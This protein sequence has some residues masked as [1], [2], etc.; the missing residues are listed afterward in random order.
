[1]ASD[2]FGGQTYCHPLADEDGY[3]ELYCK[4]TRQCSVHG[5]KPETCKAGPVTFDVNFRTRKVEFYL[6][7][8]EV[9]A[10]GGIL[11]ANKKALQ[12]HLEAAMEEINRLILQ[13]DKEELKAVLLIP[14]P[15]T[16]KIH[17]NDLPIQVADKLGI[18]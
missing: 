12:D 11:W 15:H 18:A 7:N 2:L 1:M 5:V 16:F 8:S 9:C 14:E 17:E 10:F 6:K 3:C 13:L 4:E